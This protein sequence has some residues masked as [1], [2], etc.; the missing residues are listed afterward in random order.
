LMDK[1]AA[2]GG[3]P[4]ER[5]KALS[6]AERVLIDE[7]GNIPLLY[8]GYKNLVAPKVKGFEENVMDVH[9]TRFI[10]IE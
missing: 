2:A 9:P 8:Y 7:V 1:A 6:E 10:S 4:E 5:M 3:K